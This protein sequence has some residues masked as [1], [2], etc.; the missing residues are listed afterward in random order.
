MLLPG[1][2]A[3]ALVLAVATLLPLVYA[4]PK[5][6]TP[7]KCSTCGLHVFASEWH[8]WTPP[9]PED[10]YEELWRHVHEVLERRELRL[11]R[12]NVTR[13]IERA[14]YVVKKF[15]ADHADHVLNLTEI[16]TEHANITRSRLR[17]AKSIIRAL[18]LNVT[19][20]VLELVESILNA[21][22]A[23]LEN[24]TIKCRHCLVL[25][26]LACRH[27]CTFVLQNCNCSNL[28][29]TECN[30]CRFNCS[31]TSR[32]LNLTV[33]SPGAYISLF[34]VSGHGIVML[35]L[36]VITP[37]TTLSL[38]LSKTFEDNRFVLLIDNRAVN[39]TDIHYVLVGNKSSH[40][41]WILHGVAVKHVILHS[42][43]SKV[44]EL[45]VLP[46]AT[47]ATVDAP[48]GTCSAVVLLNVSAAP[49]NVT[50]RYPNGTVAALPR[51]VSE[52][53]PCMS[54]IYHPENSTL[55]VYVR[56][57]SPVTV[58]ASFTVP[59]AINWLYVAVA[60]ALIAAILLA[61]YM[62]YRKRAIAT[63]V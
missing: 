18:V 25:G 42:N 9:G 55:V 53:C 32:Y 28:N 37:G 6:A 52:P 43:A 15:C 1:I 16:V 62:Y 47:V 44:L 14:R 35:N 22:Y 59:T 54:W 41:V 2:L 56:H 27:N 17:L 29:I 39:L 11:G 3:V 23:V 30:T 60:A 26:K 61:A 20:S 12:E 10:V 45:E 36:T 50:A 51:C 48:S 46:N 40:K 33:I 63:I 57:S 7:V 49:L 4:K 8:R 21:S 5:H 58:I 31:V 34:R 38:T 24:V 13:V 19:N